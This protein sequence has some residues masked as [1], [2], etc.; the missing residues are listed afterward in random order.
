MA[1]GKPSRYAARLLLLALGLCAAMV[2]FFGL[3]GASMPY[4]DPTAAMLAA[5]ER[6]ILGWQ[7]GLLAGLGVAAL[8]ALGLWRGRR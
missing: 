4:Q 2:S 7:S 1:S 3:A 5:Q 6:S 8:A